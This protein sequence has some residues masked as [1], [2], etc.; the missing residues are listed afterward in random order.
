MAAERVIVLAAAAARPL[1]AAVGAWVDARQLR[2]LPV[3]LAAEA[4]SVALRA[5]PA[6][7]ILD[8]RGAREAETAE[9][10]AACR[11]LKS[12]SFTGIVPVVVLVDD[13][14]SACERAF[15][16]GADEVL[17]EGAAE[18]EVGAGFVD[19]YAAAVAASTL[20]N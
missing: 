9:A 15:A 8:A 4:M 16:A 3:R 14:R 17:R 5:L 19:A 2:R 13:E 10:H 20:N 12:D 7:A 18:W 1:P 11:R 6:V